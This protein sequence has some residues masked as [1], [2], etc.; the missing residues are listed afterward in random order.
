MVE[1]AG[2]ALKLG[3]RAWLRLR[4]LDGPAPGRT[5]SRGVTLAP[6]LLRHL[7]TS[8]A[9]PPPLSPG[10]AISLRPLIGRQLRVRLGGTTASPQVRSFLP[11]DSRVT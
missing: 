6:D 10:T 4:V 3:A 11:P 5:F 7:W 1:D 8:A 2:G 9:L